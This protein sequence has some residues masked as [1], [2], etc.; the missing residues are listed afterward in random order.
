MVC[1]P[2]IREVGLAARSYELDKGQLPK[3]IAD[4]VPAF[5]KAVPK[6]P[7]TGAGMTLP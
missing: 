3:D 4:L 5:L 6:D 7:L 1:T 2:R